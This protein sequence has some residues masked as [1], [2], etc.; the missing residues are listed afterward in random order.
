MYKPNYNHPVI[1]QTDASDYGL[2]SRIFQRVNGDEHNIG[3]YSRKFSPVERGMP[4]HFRELV[5]LGGGRQSG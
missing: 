2:G 4:V 1:V 3:F 5:A